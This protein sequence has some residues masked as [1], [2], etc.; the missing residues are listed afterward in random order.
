MLNSWATLWGIHPEAVADL[1]RRLT[2]EID[3]VVPHD[4]KTEAGVQASIMLGASSTG[5]RLW[6]NNSGAATDQS[7][8]LIRYGLANTSA[9][10]S[11]RIK[12]SDLIGIRPILIG[13]EHVGQTFG[14]FVAIEVKAPGW[15]YRGNDREKAQMRYIQ[16]VVGLGGHAKFSNDPRETV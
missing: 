8:R 1:R 16:I 7:G 2:G 5:S 12:S 3:T 14:Q 9:V 11:K 10:A 13:P 6:R 15:K 4:L